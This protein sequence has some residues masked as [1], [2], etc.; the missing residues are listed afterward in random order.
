MELSPELTVQLSSVAEI[1]SAMRG[2][3][4]FAVPAHL[5]HIAQHNPAGRPSNFDRAWGKN[6]ETVEGEALCAKLLLE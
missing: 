1:K 6:A 4:V 3:G 5:V 2:D